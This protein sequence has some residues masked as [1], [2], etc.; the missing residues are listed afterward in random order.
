MTSGKQD[1]WNS[2]PVSRLYQKRFQ[3][4]RAPRDCPVGAEI[5]EDF[6]EAKMTRWHDTMVDQPESDHDAGYAAGWTISGLAMLGA[7][8]TVWVFAI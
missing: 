4:K 7:I 3:Q 6:Q 2:S 1:G 5:K 8:V